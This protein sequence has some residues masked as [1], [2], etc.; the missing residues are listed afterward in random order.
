M[1]LII[2]MELKSDAIPGNGS[3][4]AGIIDR[5]ISYDA[6]GLPFIPGKRI[7]GILKESAEEL[8]FD[9]EKLRELFG[10]EGSDAC[11]FR[12]D[13]G[14]LEGYQ[15]YCKLLSS[16]YKKIPIKTF[17]P[18]QLV[19]KYFTYSRSQT[20]IEHGIAKKNFLRTSRVLKKGLVFR[21]SVECDS[22]YKNG[23]NSISDIET[24]CKVT[25]AFGTSRTRGFGE[26]KLTVKKEATTNGQKS[27]TQSSS[28]APSQRIS[29]ITLGIDNIG[30]LLVSSKPGKNQTSESYIPGS[31]IL[32]AVA[33]NYLKKKKNVDTTFYD[34]FLSGKVRFG[35]LYPCTGETN[36]IC[37]PS[38]L[39]IKK[40]KEVKEIKEENEHPAV[41]DYID[42]SYVKKNGNENIIDQVLFKG[43]FPEFVSKENKTVSVKRQVEA[44]H[45]RPS[46][47]HIAKSTEADGEFFQFEVI[48]ANQ[49]FAGEIIGETSLLE[50]LFSYFPE[51]GMVWL[52]K[53]KTGQ[54]GKCTYK[55]SKLI[56]VSDQDEV[57]WEV[58]TEKR[59]VLL[60]DTILLN[61]NGFPSP[62]V[63]VFKKEL[64]LNIK[65]D[66][67]KLEI[68]DC[69]AKHTLAGGFL[70]VWKMPK[71]QQA[72]L[73]AGTVIVIKNNHDND[74]TFKP[75]E[76]MSFGVRTEEGFGRIALDRNFEE[77]NTS[78]KMA[79]PQ[80]EDKMQN[81]SELDGNKKFEKPV[82][83]FL[84]HQITEYINRNLQQKAIHK[85]QE[86]KKF[87]TNA[88]LGKII[89]L[90]KN[91]N[92]YESFNQKISS[93]TSERQKQNMRT[94]KK[95]LCLDFSH[96]I[97]IANSTCKGSHDEKD[98]FTKLFE[99]SKNNI[100]DVIKNNVEVDPDFSLYKAYS[101]YLLTQIKLKNRKS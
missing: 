11:A 87:P 84:K 53:S 4:I 23:K 98:N 50:K 31:T 71:I 15:E 42:L 65:V 78:W 68:T 82:E 33:I 20:S 70:G 62:D 21:F 8:R 10:K 85:L 18:P 90:L 9:D 92:S 97:I 96:N 19:L 63:E 89:K 17:L 39:S 16:T 88:F 25:R 58:G 49:Q 30:P 79:V 44:H 48:T 72:A 54:Y 38:P 28:S 29:K 52:G 35:N 6:F 13:N 74:I 67:E 94:L 66:P 100:P 45:R 73:T 93:L 51:D 57:I 55:L 24:I 76:T 2:Q 32:G 56:P 3:S 7:K 69:Y 83:K 36:E 5:D 37:Y 41:G 64:A 46:N 99:E 12:I 77:K 81:V 59:F 101:L 60:S 61:E 43:G 27:Q 26:I 1:K 86:A 34:L 80:Q 95:L 22:K 47:R 75:L 91:S 40:V 14:Y